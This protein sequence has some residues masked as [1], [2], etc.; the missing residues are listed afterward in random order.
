[1]IM[2]PRVFQRETGAVLVKHRIEETLFTADR[3]QERVEELAAAITEDYRD[4]SPFVMV[5]ILNGAFIFMADLVRQIRIPIEFDFMELSSYGSST[6]ASGV[7]RIGKDLGV[8]ITDRHVLIIED[9]IDTGLTLRFLERDLAGRGA[10]SIEI[11]ALLNKETVNKVD[12]PVR[13]TG[14]TIPDRYVVGY[15]LDLAG[16]YRNLP[17]IAAVSTDG[18]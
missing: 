4:R 15:G 5:G 7:I 10:A 18:E 17:Y 13:Y 11:C 6:K 1:M 12:I 16:K 14:F 8:D 3:I 9:I 2:L